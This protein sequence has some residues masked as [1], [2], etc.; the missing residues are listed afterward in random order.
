VPLENNLKG[1]AT[2]DAVYMKKAF[3]TS[4]KLIFVRGGIYTTR[5]FAEYSVGLFHDQ[6]KIKRQSSRLKL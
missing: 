1:H 5:T 3:Y 2:G 4:G 6:G